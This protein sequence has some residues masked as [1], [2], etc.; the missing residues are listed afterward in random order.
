MGP[1][2]WRAFRGVR[3]PGRSVARWVVVG[4]GAA[5]VAGAIV[6]GAGPLQ[7]TQSF[8]RAVGC[9][10]CFGTDRGSITARETY[11]TTSTSTDA[12]GN[13]NTRTETH[14][15][16][17]WR[18]SDGSTQS[19]DVSKNFYDKATEGQ[20]ADLRIWRG[21]VVGV[22]VM[23]ATER[24]L[25]GSSRTLVYW[26]YLG[27]LGL[28]VLLW[29]LLFG[30]WDG[31]FMLAYRTFAWMFLVLMPASMVTHG[32]AYGFEFGTGTIIQLVLAVL[33]AAIAVALLVGSLSAF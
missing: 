17:T 30:W 18:R 31:L 23:G 33:F 28:G 4:I 7:Q 29:G 19:R 3:W 20:P 24:F 21:E 5:I 15:E 16:I 9:D 2:R 25:P 11:T 26:I 27:F 1:R 12:N 32:L 22:E 13:S 14:Y 8:H 6:G 10:D